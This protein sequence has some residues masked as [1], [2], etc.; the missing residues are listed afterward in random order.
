MVRLDGCDGRHTP[1]EVFEWVFLTVVMENV[2]LSRPPA[3]SS[4]SQS[5]E[6]RESR[7]R[8]AE[9]ERVEVFFP[10]GATTK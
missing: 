10:L 8:R 1:G 3:A 7:A 6:R 5:C 4:S 9:E 2:R